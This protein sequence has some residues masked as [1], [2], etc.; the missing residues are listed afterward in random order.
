M[1]TVE[2]QFLH[3]PI[4]V[5]F[6]NRDVCIDK[7]S[8]KEVNIRKVCA[9]RCHINRVTVSSNISRSTVTGDTESFGF[10]GLS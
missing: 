7:V 3:L 9:I 4:E 5:T 6:L 10:L 8:T 2:V 1:I